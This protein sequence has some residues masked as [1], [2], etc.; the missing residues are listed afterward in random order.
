MIISKELSKILSA[1]YT[2]FPYWWTLNRSCW[3]GVRREDFHIK[4]EMDESVKWKMLW[5]SYFMQMETVEFLP[6]LLLCARFVWFACRASLLCFG[7]RQT[8]MVCWLVV[9][10][11][12]LIPKSAD[13]SCK[14]KAPDWAAYPNDRLSPATA[15]ATELGP[16]V[17]RTC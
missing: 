6:A 12:Q 15:R 2:T 3:R 13:F 17:S 5:I 8:T 4:F 11:I 14:W 1:F 9:M 10:F 7:S 16:G